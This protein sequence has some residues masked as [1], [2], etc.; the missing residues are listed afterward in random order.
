M[1]GLGE[2]TAL[3][4]GL[5]ARRL[6][7]DDTD[8]GLPAD[9]VARVAERP[10][11][12]RWAATVAAEALLEARAFERVPFGSKAAFAAWAEGMALEDLPLLAFRTAHRRLL[13]AVRDLIER[14]GDLLNRL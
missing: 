2:A 3:A 12:H 11:R 7:A 13:V 8:L 10:I 4:S 9:D 5:D 14:L 1:W 6:G